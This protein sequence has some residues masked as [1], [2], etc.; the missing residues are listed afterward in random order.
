[1]GRLMGR[2][3]DPT[4][5]VARAARRLLAPGEPVLAAVHVARP[6]TGQ[7]ELLAGASGAVRGAIQSTLP[8]RIQGDDGFDEWLRQATGFG[9]APD[10]ARKAIHLTVVL[11]P[12]RVL[13][14]RRS[15]LTRRP[16]EVIA[17]WSVLDIDRIEVPRNGNRLTLH[18]DGASLTLELPQAHRFLPDVYRDLPARLAR[19]QEEE[20]RRRSTD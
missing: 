2:R 14:V 19:A 15:S 4:P 3:P 8:P 16:K 17:A 20:R 9:L 1:M 12:G 5:H 11:T 6:G 10:I 18:R 7:A 13:L